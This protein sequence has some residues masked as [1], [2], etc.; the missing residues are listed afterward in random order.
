MSS[1]LH[2]NSRHGFHFPFITSFPTTVTTCNFIN[3]Q[4]KQ[5]EENFDSAYA[6]AKQ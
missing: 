1:K 3:R 4:S 5:R 2:P 6:V